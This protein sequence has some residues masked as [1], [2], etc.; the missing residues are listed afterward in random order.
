MN[1]SAGQGSMCRTVVWER[2]M[3]AETFGRIKAEI[4]NL[5]RKVWGL[6]G[7]HGTWLEAW[8]GARYARKEGRGHGCLQSHPFPGPQFPCTG[9]TWLMTREAGVR[10][11][12]KRHPQRSTCLQLEGQG[13]EQGKTNQLVK[14]NL[15]NSWPVLHVILFS[16]LWTL[17]G[18][19][20]WQGG[21]SKGMSVTF[22]LQHMPF[23]CGLS[24]W[25]SWLME[26]FTVEGWQM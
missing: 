25:E 9:R 1:K 21:M 26:E 16:C 23:L 24:S 13:E 12:S 5:E 17:R 4:H 7:W 6:E 3:P 10:E 20:E 14:M 18:G 8:A 11:A 22:Q 15:T 2:I 19:G